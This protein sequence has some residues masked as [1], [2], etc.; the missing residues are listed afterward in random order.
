MNDI[1]TYH[2]RVRGSVDIA[3]LNGASPFLM[4][5]QG[6]APDA[7]MFSIHTDQSGLIGLLRH[8]HSLGLIFLSVQ[9]EETGMETEIA[10][11]LKGLSHE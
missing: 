7:A 8:L 2:I 11:E 3:E 10:S 9:R 4:V 1:C 6:S 5:P